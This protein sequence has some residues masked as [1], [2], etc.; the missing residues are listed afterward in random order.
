MLLTDTWEAPRALS[1]ARSSVFNFLRWVPSILLLLPWLLAPATPPEVSRIR[2]LSSAYGFHLLD[3]ETVHVSQK[4][5]PLWAGLTGSAS[6]DTSGD[7]AV[8]RAYFAQSPHPADLRPGAETAL[9]H[10]VAQAY[11]DG[12]VLH[13]EPLGLQNLFPPVLINLTPPPNVLV[14]APRNE[15]RVIDSSVLGP[16]DVTA[17]EQLEAS[18]DSTGVSSLVAPIGGLATYPSMVLDNDSAQ[19]VLSASA[20]EW[21]HQYLIFYPLGQGYWNSQQTREINETTAEL[22]GDE[23]GAGIASQIG[24]TAP[25]PAAATPRASRRPAFDFRSFMR[26]TRAQVEQMLAAGQVDGAEA[27]MRAQRDELQRH[28][29]QI[30]KLNQ[31]YFALYGSYGDSYAASPAN[32][33]PGLLHQLR[34]QS[35]S[36]G[37]FLVRVRGITTVDDLRKAA[38]G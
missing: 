8:L 28:G 18:A 16:M 24:L 32:P 33:I 9:E 34:T 35:S 14:I 7:A 4:L 12:G 5:G 10:L 29:Y 2:D 25:G 11:R 30:R 21:V 36:I 26:D 3:W 15:L 20:H 27:Y 1:Y 19:Q 22:I 38:V 37:D 23:V 13:S 6:G 17:Q 31:A